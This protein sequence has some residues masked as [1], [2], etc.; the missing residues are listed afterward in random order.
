MSKPSV[1]IVCFLGVIPP[2]TWL[3]CR[4]LEK[5]GFNP[6]I[7][8]SN[9]TEN[10]TA[11]KYPKTVFVNTRLY[12]RLTKKKKL[13]RLRVPA[14]YLEYLTMVLITLW[15]RVSP[16]DRIQFSHPLLLLLTTLLRKQ[17]VA[18]YYDAFEFYSL[19]YDELGLAGHIYARLCDILERHFL[20]NINGVI[21]TAS[22]SSWLKHRLARLN[23]NT[24][25]L[26]N[27]PTVHLD[28]KPLCRKLEDL[29]ANKKIVVYA[30]GLKPEKGI[31]I[32][33]P[34]V[35]KVI[36]ADSQCHFLLIG[37]ICGPDSADRWLK[38]H[39]IASVCT[40]IPWM[41]PP[42]LAA[43]LRYCSVGLILMSPKNAYRALGAGGGRKLYTYMAAGLP[44]VAPS[45]G[46][47]W[48]IV[49]EKHIGLQVDTTSYKAV[50]QAVISLL[51]DTESR[52]RMSERARILF[53]TDYNWER[54]ESEYVSHLTAAQS[55]PTPIG[56]GMRK[57]P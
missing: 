45:F 24:L 43:C 18:F 38:D 36:Q 4:S 57:A 1:F 2:R 11:G 6:C 40:Y 22:K 28:D 10:T 54:F 46:I 53:L 30:G 55:M 5:F 8:A 20:P 9:C 12:H 21:C 13:R 23:S 49:T 47:A 50:S 29:S 39:Q 48:N 31:E 37:N 27:L 52:I 16:G 15:R 32:F 14:V 7:I 35:K 17:R 41:S 34:T 56:R 3:Q 19:V 26:H 33:V 44:V 25:E 51:R 42:R